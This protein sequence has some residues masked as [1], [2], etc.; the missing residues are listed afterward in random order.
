MKKKVSFRLGPINLFTITFL[1]Y[2]LLS[3]VIILN[4]SSQYS[5]IT[6]ISISEMYVIR[7]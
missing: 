2:Y 1:I 5:E 4:S 6:E 3:D 7:H